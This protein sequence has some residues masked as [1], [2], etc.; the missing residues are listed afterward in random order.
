[1]DESVEIARPPDEVARYLFDWRNDPEWIGGIEEA[2]LLGDES[3]LRTGSQVER[4]AS[5]LGRRI[6]YVLEVEEYE[7]GALLAMRSVRGPFPMTVG[8]EVSDAPPGTRVRVL[9]GGDASGFHRVAGP[10][11]NLQARRSI[12]ADLRRLQRL[13]EARQDA[14]DGRSL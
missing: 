1:V 11:L 7:P 5:F 2:R 10:L 3:E 9:V 14:R 6:E 12:A 8:Y 4:V 13:L